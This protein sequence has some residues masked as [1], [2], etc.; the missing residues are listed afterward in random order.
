MDK[1][2][3]ND[4]NNFSH[5]SSSTDKLDTSKSKQIADPP[6][7]HELDAHMDMLA[8]N[9]SYAQDTSAEPQ[10]IQSDEFYRNY[11]SG[12][13]EM[14]RNSLTHANEMMAN[15]AL[16]ASYEY[17]AVR[18]YEHAMNGLTGATAFDRYDMN[19]SSLYASSLSMQRPNISYPSYL[20]TFNS[21][22]VAAA[23]THQ[24]YFGEHGATG[25]AGAPA[26]SA[27]IADGSA[28][29]YPKPMYHYDS[30]FPLGGF[31]A[32]NLALRSS[33]VTNPL[34]II[35]LSAT[36]V[37]A[38][39]AP[40]STTPQYSMSHR[41]TDSNVI[42]KE[43]E[44]TNSGSQVGMGNENRRRPTNATKND[45]YSAQNDNFSA[46]QRAKSP[47]SE[48]VDLCN[49]AGS[50]EGVFSGENSTENTQNRPFSRSDSTSDSGASP[51]IDTLKTDSMGE[52][53]I[54]KIDKIATIDW[55]LNDFCEWNRF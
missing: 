7:K 38:S 14:G 47:Q 34:P 50:K 28:P 16:V 23:A 24:K 31:S 48:P 15:R 12:A 52:L 10:P 35:D 17:S 5:T 54:I 13:G 22:D 27:G 4:Y 46:Y 39:S 2:K 41:S 37:T 20:N 11:A 3:P 9:A 42:G 19:L 53:E 21:D 51:Y 26:V 36:N 55:Y 43:T 29:Y 32:M 44:V 45:G 49:V 40:T 6:T 30:T 18:N 33:T 25:G 8:Q 1:S